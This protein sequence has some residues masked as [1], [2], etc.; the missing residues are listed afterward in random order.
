MLKK[1]NASLLVL[2][3]VLLVSSIYS[4]DSDDDESSSDEAI[5]DDGVSIADKMQTIC[6]NITEDTKLD[7][8]QY[9]VYGGNFCSVVPSADITKLSYITADTKDIGSHSEVNSNQS[10]YVRESR[11]DLYADYTMFKTD[12]NSYLKIIENLENAGNENTKLLITPIEKLSFNPDKTQATAK[13]ELTS[14]EQQN[15]YMY[16]K[17]N[18]KLYGKKIGDNKYLISLDTYEIGEESKLQEA[19]IMI[20]IMTYSKGIYINVL[21]KVGLEAL[22]INSAMGGVLSEILVG[23]LMDINQKYGLKKSQN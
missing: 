9:P 18:W 23:I 5:Y 8:S 17:N 2:V 20:A 22:G 6:T 11:F 1:I 10:L 12:K 21:T 7:L 14:T 3:A 16:I 15:G 19:H 4:C 13:F